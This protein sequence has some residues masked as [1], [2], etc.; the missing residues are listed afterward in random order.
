VIRHIISFLGQRCLNSPHVFLVMSGCFTSL[1]LWREFHFSNANVITFPMINQTGNAQLGRK[2]STLIKDSVVKIVLN[3]RWF[4]GF[5]FIFGKWFFKGYCCWSK[6]QNPEIS[7]KLNGLLDR[8][9]KVLNNSENSKCFFDKYFI[10]IHFSVYLFSKFSAAICK[11]L[12]AVG[13]Q[14]IASFIPVVG[15]KICKLFNR[16]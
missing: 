9:L 16:Q 1:S 5:Y 2:M 8:N 15:R 6:K 14:H 10:N 12:P 3:L 7:R 11:L 4:Y 13:R